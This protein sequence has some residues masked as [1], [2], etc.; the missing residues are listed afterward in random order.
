MEIV[1]IIDV[2]VS[3][4]YILLPNAWYIQF[5]KGKWSLFSG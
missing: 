2:N 5:I 4:Q 1:N 3:T